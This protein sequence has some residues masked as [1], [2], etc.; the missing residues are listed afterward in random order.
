VPYDGIGC[1][2]PVRPELAA[3]PGTRPVGDLRL[4]LFKSS[5]MP[6]VLTSCLPT[7]SGFK[8]SHAGTIKLPLVADGH[9]QA[10]VRQAR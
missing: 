9:S 6:P 10:P 8:L 7:G 5:D 2:W 1:L 4:T 3:S